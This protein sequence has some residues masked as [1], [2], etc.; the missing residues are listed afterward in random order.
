MWHGRLLDGHFE[1]IE[2]TRTQRSDA[3][4]DAV[5]DGAKD[6]TVAAEPRQWWS[7]SVEEDNYMHENVAWH[8]VK[9]GKR[10]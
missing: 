5:Q 1:T 10:D 2:A 3:D 6:T 8:L 9:A 7:K 4:V